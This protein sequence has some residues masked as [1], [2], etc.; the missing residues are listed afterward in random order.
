MADWVIQLSG[1]KFDL[2]EIAVPFERE[3]K[4]IREKERKE[5]KEEKQKK[6]TTKK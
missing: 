2:E 6:K 4:L 3:G 5:N 1:E